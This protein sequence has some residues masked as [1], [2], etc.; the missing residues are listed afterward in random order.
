MNSRRPSSQ[1]CSVTMSV[2]ATSPVTATWRTISSSVRHQSGC[3]RFE[4]A[5]QYGA[6]PA[7]SFQPN[8]GPTV[9]S[10]A[11]TVNGY[12]DAIFA[13]VERCL[14]TDRI[15]GGTVRFILEPSTVIASL[16]GGVRNSLV[17]P[18]TIARRCCSRLTLYAQLRRWRGD[19]APDSSATFSVAPRG[20]SGVRRHSLWVVVRNRTKPG[21]AAGR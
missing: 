8:S 15:R 14:P 5:E 7:A 1:Q 2:R 21:S 12:N 11:C 18:S 17:S 6:P 9:G 4:R 16:T 20:A 10:G 3:V 13:V 19:D